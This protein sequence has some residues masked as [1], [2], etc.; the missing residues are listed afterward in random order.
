[1]NRAAC[2]FE[3]FR[4]P[5][6]DFLQLIASQRLSLGSPA[7]GQQLILARLMKA[8]TRQCFRSVNC[9]WKTFFEGTQSPGS[10]TRSSGWSFHIRLPE[11][12]IPAPNCGIDFL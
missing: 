5:R 9:L 11:I 7:I 12:H 4:W 1:M 6:Q 8:P 10:F 2:T 3:G